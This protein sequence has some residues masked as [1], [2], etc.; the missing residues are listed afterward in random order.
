MAANI[1]ADTLAGNAMLKP[2]DI[3]TMLEVPD[4][5]L[6]DTD[7]HNYVTEE[8]YIH[9][10]L[11]IVDDRYVI[12]GSANLNDRSQLGNR[13]SEVALL[14]EDQEFVPSRMNG[15]P[16]Q[17]AKF[18]Y[19]LRAQLFKEHLGLI[20]SET[21]EF[22]YDKVPVT[23]EDIDSLNP[24]A[25]DISVIGV[26]NNRVPSSAT[27][28]RS[29]DYETTESDDLVMDPLADEFYLNLW[30]KT[31]ATNT[32]IFRDVFRCTPDDTVSTLEEYRSFVDSKT[33]PGHVAHID[34]RQTGEVHSKL[35]K[36]RG[37][38]VEFPTEF[39][40]QENL[41]GSVLKE[42]VVPMEIFT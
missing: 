2:T 33:M 18:A 7:I 13:D 34:T 9:T 8:L 10:K 6:S 11:M 3:L 25:K 4:V 31:A 15:K 5:K 21:H 12:C 1:M 22:S 17:A 38:L 20:P 16:Y 40:K 24:N 37:H 27:F 14:V 30:L 36:V 39:L 42:A 19:D 28:Y 41:V 35:S 29:P 32:E 23:P 26:L